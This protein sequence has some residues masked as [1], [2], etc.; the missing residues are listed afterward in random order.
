MRSAVVRLFGEDAIESVDVGPAEDET[1]EP[2]LSYGL[3]TEPRANVRL[4]KMSR[5]DRR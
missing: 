1:G 5:Y 4:A 3:L 2:A